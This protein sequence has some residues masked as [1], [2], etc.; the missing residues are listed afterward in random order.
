MLS[1]TEAHQCWGMRRQLV[2]NPWRRRASFLRP[3]DPNGN[4]SLKWGHN[5]L[6][7]VG[8]RE[9]LGTG[10][11]EIPRHVRAGRDGT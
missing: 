10:P 4:R 6:S 7:I 8:N 11:L 2:P 9:G 1:L 3:A 5:R